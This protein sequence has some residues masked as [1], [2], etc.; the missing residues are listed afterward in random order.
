MKVYSKSDI[1]LV[2][3]SNQD[4][5]DTGW[6]SK[7]S[8][9]AIVCDGMGGAN[10]GSTASHN[11]VD[12]IANSIKKFDPD[13]LSCDEIKN[14]MLKITQDVN[15]KIYEIAK[16]N[17]SLL[18]MGTTIVFLI[19]SNGI[20]HF[21]HAGD[22]RAYVISNNVITQVTKDHSIVQE[23]VE[24]GK[25]TKEQAQHHPEKNVITRALGVYENLDLDYFQY[26]L[27]E[28]DVILICTDGLT[29]YLNDTELLNVIEEFGDERAVDE[30]ISKAN[31]C[32]GNDN[33]TAVLIRK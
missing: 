13:K 3:K 2:R 19:I 12:F 21:V 30:Y 25:I 14:L 32:G 31:D 16:Q 22:S 4:Y 10:G 24:S 15:R 9:F 11:A 5:F 17:T 6:F 28:N 7:E 20:A 1:G 18:G 8:L 26:E 27:S 23:L 29:N 33:I